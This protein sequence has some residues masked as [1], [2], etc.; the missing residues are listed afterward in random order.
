MPRRSLIL[1]LIRR[2]SKTSRLLHSW[3]KKPIFFE[4]ILY[5]S[6]KYSAELEASE[7]NGFQPIIKIF[8]IFLDTNGMLGEPSN[9]AQAVNAD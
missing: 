9:L 5:N 4:F 2:E 6:R 8:S 7:V 1:G 3:C